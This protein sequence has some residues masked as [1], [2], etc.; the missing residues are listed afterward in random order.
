MQRSLHSRTALLCAAGLP[1]LVAVS[2]RRLFFPPIR[3]TGVW[4][5]CAGC[6]AAKLLLRIQIQTQSVPYGA[7]SR[8]DLVCTVC[9]VFGAKH[10]LVGSA[11]AAKPAQQNRTVVRCLPGDW[12]E[13]PVPDI[14]AS[15]QGKAI[16][17]GFSAIPRGTGP[18]VQSPAVTAFHQG[19]ILLRGIRRHLPRVQAL[20]SSP[21]NTCP[22]M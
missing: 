19:K 11:G 13:G 16:S 4:F 3:R 8:A 21:L 12:I 2:V 6:K 22:A 7:G 18:S 5:S 20:R 17:A 15:L 10:N 1:R 9:F 14:T